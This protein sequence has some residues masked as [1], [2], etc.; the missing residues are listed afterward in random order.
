MDIDGA[1]RIPPIDED[2]VII[3]PSSQPYVCPWKY[4][5]VDTEWQQRSCLALGLR[6]IGPNGVT[7]GGPEVPL[8]KPGR[9]CV[10]GDGNCFFRAVSVIITGSEEQHMDVRRVLVRHMRSIGRLIVKRADPCHH[11]HGVDHYIAEV[12]MDCFGAWAT[13]VE[14]FALA[15]LLHINIFVY[16]AD[17]RSAEWS[18]STP[19]HVDNT[20]PPIDHSEMGIYMR[21]Q[22]SHYEGI[23]SVVH[24]PLHPLMKHHIKDKNST[25]NYYRPGVQHS[26]KPERNMSVS[27]RSH[28]K[29]QDILIVVVPDDG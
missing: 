19:R 18:R 6:Y 10:L 2:D 3:L 4:H 23:K 25:T 16:L 8:T 26:S 21:L 14:I 27:H 15:H 28:S 12:R 17:L 22:H 29:P 20:L 13:E 7:P 11:Q 5:P 1:D 9:I 24:L